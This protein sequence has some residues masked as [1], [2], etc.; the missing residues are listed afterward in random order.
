MPDLAGKVVIVTG[1]SSGIGKEIVK[2]IL[3]LGIRK[4]GKRYQLAE[5]TGRTA[6]FLDLDL[7]DLKSVKAAA[8]KFLSYEREESIS[9]SIMGRTMI[10]AL[11]IVCS[12][13]SR[14]TIIILA[15]M[16]SVPLPALL[17][18]KG[19]ARVVTA[20]SS[21]IY[22]PIGS[23]ILFETQ[24][25]IV[26]VLSKQSVVLAHMTR[27]WGAWTSLWAGT[28]P[29]YEDANGK[30]GAMTKLTRGPEFRDYGRGWKNR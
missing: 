7:G 2:Y 17:S 8:E 21:A 14:A 11:A 29:E 10:D 24:V 15:L 23:K 30:E 28:S 20:S 16:S 26:S 25:P 4:D 22:A 27:K 18:T 12:S 5:A 3:P 13:V 1:G 6:I 9:Y 19:M